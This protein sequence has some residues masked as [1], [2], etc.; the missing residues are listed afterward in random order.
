MDGTIGQSCL[1]GNGIPPRHWRSARA[2]IL[3]ARGICVAGVD[4]QIQQFIDLHLAH[5]RI[6]PLHP[7]PLKILD[8]LVTLVGGALLTVLSNFY[9]IVI[10]AI[11]LAVACVLYLAMRK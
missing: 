10:L 8:A 4:I 11:V 1:F 7:L 6:D 3:P 5:S 9:W 2:K